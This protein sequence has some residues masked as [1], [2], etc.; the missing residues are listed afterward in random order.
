MVLRYNY[1]WG[2]MSYQLG[3]AQSGALAQ[4]IA[5]ATKNASTVAFG[6]QGGTA[7]KA[8]L[9]D[10]QALGFSRASTSFMVAGYDPL[11]IAMFD[12]D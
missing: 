12:R 9:A 8:A 3:P 10:L 2:S 7:Q 4:E 1:N 5:A 11:E 6:Y